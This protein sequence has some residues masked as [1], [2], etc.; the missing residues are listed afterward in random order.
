MA[1]LT[2]VTMNLT[3]VDVINAENLTKQLES[4]S[5]AS[6]ISTSLSVTAIIVNAIEKGSEIVIRN[7]DKT[8][9]RLHIKGLN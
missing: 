1:K 4:R 3:E 2:K 6:T 7:R 9:E 5:K 8:I